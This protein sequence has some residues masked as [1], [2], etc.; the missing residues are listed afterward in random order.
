MKKINYISVIFIGLLFACTSNDSVP[1]NILDKNQMVGVIVN[2]E[3]N[4][5]MYKLKFANKDSVNY[6]Q[7]VN[8][9]FTKQ[10]TSKEQFNNSL[11]YYAEHPIVLKEIYDEA[12]VVLTEKQAENQSKKSK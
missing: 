1:N 4:Q 11:S 3:L 10:S 8:Q 2:L 6:M 7:M 12:I 9:T 5:A